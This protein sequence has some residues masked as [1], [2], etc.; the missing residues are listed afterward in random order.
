MKNKITLREDEIAIIYKNISEH[1]LID[2]FSGLSLLNWKSML[3]NQDDLT[4]EDFM[5]IMKTANLCVPNWQRLVNYREFSTELLLR[6]NSIHK[7]FIEPITFEVG[8]NTQDR[9]LIFR[10]P[11]YLIN[12]DFKEYNTEIVFGSLPLEL[13]E[14]IITVFGEL[15]PKKSGVMSY[16]KID[17]M[18]IYLHK[19]I[20]F[21]ENNIRYCHKYIFEPFSRID[22]NERMIYQITDNY[23]FIKTVNEFITTRYT[24]ELFEKEFKDLTNDELTVLKMRVI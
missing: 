9:R 2:N 6:F 10:V 20:L 5:K 4:Q 3:F 11:E 19:F 13:M 16:I 12:K 17:E 7:E 24:E 23:D 8:E 22:A 15:V 18:C 1:L 21:E 14:S